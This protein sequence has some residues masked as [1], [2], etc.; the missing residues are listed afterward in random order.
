MNNKYIVSIE[1][2]DGSHQD[3]NQFNTFEEGEKFMD[4]Y[5][6][7]HKNECYLHLLYNDESVYMVGFEE[8]IN[9]WLTK[10]IIDDNSIDDEDRENQFELVPHIDRND[11]T[12][13]DV[14][15]EMYNN[16]GFEGDWLEYVQHY[17]NGGY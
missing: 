12:W 9:D 11:V 16:N 2:F 15:L 4:N 10:K 17:M 6:R 1:F 7:V 3:I 14:I 8:S 13:E 5:D